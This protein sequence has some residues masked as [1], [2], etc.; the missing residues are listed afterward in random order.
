MYPDLGTK[1]SIAPPLPEPMEQMGQLVIFTPERLNRDTDT[2]DYPPLDFIRTGYTIF[3][4]DGRQQSHVDNYVADF[5]SGP[6]EESLAPGRYLIK[7]DEPDE[8]PPYFWV[9]IEKSKRTVVEEADLNKRKTP[10]S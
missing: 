6:I 8:A 7:L 3:D 10:P 9:S 5:S 2:S 1:F 4:K